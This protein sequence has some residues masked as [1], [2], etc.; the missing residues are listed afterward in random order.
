MV[1]KL[2]T[3]YSALVEPTLMSWIRM[4]MNATKPRALI[5][6]RRVGWTALKNLEKGNPLSLAKAHVSRETDASELNI[7][8]VALK[9]MKTVNTEV[10]A[11]DPVALYTT[12]MI[13]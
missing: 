12:W 5:G 6:M 11:L 9:R 4:M 3:A 8:T 13:G 2:T 7:E 10:A 1:D